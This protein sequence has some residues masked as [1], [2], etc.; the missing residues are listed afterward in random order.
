MSGLKIRV[1]RSPK[2]H[3]ARPL[4][5]GV[6]DAWFFKRISKRNNTWNI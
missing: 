5:F 6:I 4:Q 1:T 2:A 3:E